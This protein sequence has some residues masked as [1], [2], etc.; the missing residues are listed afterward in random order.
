MPEASP[1]ALPQFL[2][3]T[4]A[5]THQYASATSVVVYEPE[6]KMTEASRPSRA[7]GK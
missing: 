2:E 4:D 1:P 7:R 3:N 5:P 6:L